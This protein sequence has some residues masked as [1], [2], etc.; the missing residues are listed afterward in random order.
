M[1]IWPRLFEGWMT[2]LWIAGYVLV[3]LVRW[4]ASSTVWTTGPE[5]HSVY[6]F[7]YVTVTDWL[8]F[9]FSSVQNTFP[10]VQNRVKN[11][12][13]ETYMKQRIAFR[14]HKPIRTPVSKPQSV[15]WSLFFFVWSTN[16]T[17][18][19]EDLAN[20]NWMGGAG[21]RKWS[22]L[23]LLLYSATANDHKRF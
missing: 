20:E 17:R 16:K 12:F 18:A 9:N 21:K 11:Y 8:I 19:A 14:A 22:V 1:K 6:C 13:L 23:H 15:H 10:S 2:L 7:Y 5:H 4:I 3:T